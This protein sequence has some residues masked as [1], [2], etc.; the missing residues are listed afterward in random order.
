M[1]SDQELLTQS[2]TLV[3]AIR[4]RPQSLTV[5][6]DLGIDYA[7]SGATTIQAAATSVGLTAPELLAMLTA[8]AD[9]AARDWNATALSELTRFLTDDHRYILAE[10]LPHLRESIATAMEM[11]GPLPLLRRMFELENHLRESIAVHAGSEEDEL[12]PIVE[13]LEAAAASHGT[14]PSLRIAARVLREVIEHES[15]RDRLH[16]LRD[17]ANELLLCCEVPAVNLALRALQKQLHQ[18]M[19]IENNVLYP[20]AIAIENGLRHKH[21]EIAAN[22]VHV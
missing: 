16:A 7:C 8:N 14:Q 2:T 5:L 3:D 21:D 19:H 4:L 6:E 11:H 17:L 18:H 22:A 10:L 15:L 20:R 13:G 12:F 9:Q 1:R